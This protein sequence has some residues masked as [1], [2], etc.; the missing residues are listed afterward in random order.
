MKMKSSY[1]SE[2]CQSCGQT[3]TYL[4]PLD[5]G[6]V[7]IV[8]IIAQ[9]IKN[10]GIN[11]IHPRKELETSDKITSNQVGNLT[12]P[13]SHGL[14]AKVKGNPG[15]YCLTQKG[16]KFLNGATVPKFAI[17]KK[18]T[19]NEHARQ[20]GYWKPEEYFVSIKD[21]VKTTEYW[22]GWNFDIQE[23]SVISKPESNNSQQTLL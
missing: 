3:T 6:S 8:R 18:S 5:K 13:R 12:H 4:L 2:V 20:I 21:F 1:N 16:A 9:G 19:H 10:K 22:E 14:I 23:G 15:N 11:A 7:E 17:M